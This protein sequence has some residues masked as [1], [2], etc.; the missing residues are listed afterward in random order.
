MRL[1]TSRVTTIMTSVLRASG[2]DCGYWQRFKSHKTDLEV[3]ILHIKH[4]CCTYFGLR[5]KR[6]KTLLPRVL[7]NFHIALQK[8]VITLEEVV[9]TH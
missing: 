1:K 4:F 2:I 8:V 9:I 7:I 5:V 3:T 6:C